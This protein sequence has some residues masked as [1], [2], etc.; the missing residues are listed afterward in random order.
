MVASRSRVGQGCARTVLLVITGLRRV[1]SAVFGK[2][3]VPCQATNDDARWDGVDAQP[4]GEDQLAPY[5]G[6][7]FCVFL[8]MRVTPTECVIT[9]EILAIYRYNCYCSAIDELSFLLQAPRCNVSEMG[10][11]RGSQDSLASHMRY[12]QPGRTSMRPS[13]TPC[14]NGYWRS[15]VPPVAGLTHH[16]VNST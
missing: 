4:V 1:W 9:T 7:I 3:P 14:G 15:W 12:A 16:R 6:H 10:A 2:V 11:R 13:P 8:L 5:R